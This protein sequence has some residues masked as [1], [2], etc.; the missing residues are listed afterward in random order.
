MLGAIAMSEYGLQVLGNTAMRR[1]ISKNEAIARRSNALSVT[2]AHDL[3]GF[4][5]RDNE[6]SI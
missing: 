1:Y 5:L 2:L 4:D 6:N 3:S